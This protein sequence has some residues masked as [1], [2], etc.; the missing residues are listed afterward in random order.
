MASNQFCAQNINNQNNNV[1]SKCLNC[2]IVDVYSH[3]HQM[4]GFAYT[5]FMLLFYLFL[6]AIFMVKMICMR[7]GDEDDR[8]GPRSNLDLQTVKQFRARLKD[9]NMD[10]EIES[11]KE[12][13]TDG[14]LRTNPR[15]RKFSIRSATFP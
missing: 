15:E 11:R 14:N 5:C 4:G 2:Q 10:F 8:D 6:T 7:R 3:E 9:N 1:T 12:K 13:M